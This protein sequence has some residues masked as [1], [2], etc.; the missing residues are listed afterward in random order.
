MQI[1]CN[2]SRGNPGAEAEEASACFA[3]VVLGLS[4]P[5]FWKLQGQT[6][7]VLLMCNLFITIL[8]FQ[9]MSN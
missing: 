6:D 2:E 5:R 9:L 7:S 8:A 1:H 4:T 3:L